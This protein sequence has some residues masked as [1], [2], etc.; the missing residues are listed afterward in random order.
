MFA[1]NSM[2]T[3]TI[4][5]ANRRGSVLVEF[6]FV[7]VIFMTL[8]LG[9]LQFGVYLNVTNSLWNLSRE[10]ARF[11]AVQKNTDAAANANIMA[12]IEKVRPPIVLASALTAKITPDSATAR[13]SGTSVTITLTYDMTSRTLFPLPFPITPGL[14][15]TYTTQTTMLVE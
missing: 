10:G 9:M 11:A 6:A 4:Y 12:Y 8:L 13:T 7:V 3:T 15:K 2:K 14:S 1:T 5:G